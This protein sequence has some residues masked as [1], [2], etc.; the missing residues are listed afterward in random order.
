MRSFLKVFFIT[1]DYIVISVLNNPILS[2]PVLS[3]MLIS[4]LHSIS[5]DDIMK[6]RFVLLNSSRA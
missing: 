1:A 5:L 2:K 3:Y 4:E 6:E